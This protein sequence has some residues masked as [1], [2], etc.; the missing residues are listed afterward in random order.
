MAKDMTKGG[1]TGILIRFCVP[2]VLS[3]LLQQMYSWA[4][5]LIVGNW[6]GEAS[7]AAIGATGGVSGLFIAIVSG[8]AVGVSILTAQAYGG[9]DREGMRGITSTFSWFLGGIA[10]LLA[11]VGIA[12]ARPLLGAL[13]TPSEVL[14][15]AGDYLSI[16]LAGIPF[17]AVYNVYSAVL[18]GIGDSRT[19]LL[20]IIV[21]SV[22]NVLLDLLFVAAF[23]WG[24]AGAAAATLISQALMTLFIVAYSGRRYAMLRLFVGKG[25]VDPALLRRGLSLS[26][27]TA[28]QSG[29]RSVGGLLLQSITNSF[30]TQTLAAIT[31]AY[32]IDSVVLLPVNNLGAGVSTFV[33]QNAGAGDLRRAR[34]GLLS[35]ALITAAVA[36]AMSALVIPMGGRL[37]A[38]FGVSREVVA[39]GQDFFRAIALFYPIYGVAVGF[40]GYLQGIGDVTY[41]GVI[42]IASG[43]VRIAL[44]YILAP[45][46]GN[47]VIAYAEMISWVF[48]LVL[49]V[50]RYLWLRR[51]GKGSV[52][53]EKAE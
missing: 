37:M 24:A 43:A 5:A 23:G 27:P 9:G 2:L 39:I 11:V 49:A 35:G 18:R 41:T 4:D 13:D 53:H 26:L 16:V 7:L 47:M 36:V 10:L 29:V 52:K 6:V 42:N 31:T 46:F 21:S 50:A 32:R 19:P 28:I 3:G 8:F 12:L 20:S 44:S 30:G 34:R 15:I 33:A 45:Y 40:I 1:I 25:M 22:A 38:L 14:P 48:L 51:R 17:L